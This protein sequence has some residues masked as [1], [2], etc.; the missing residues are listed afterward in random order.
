MSNR[1]SIPPVDGV[2]SYLTLLNTGHQ[3]GLTTV[4]ANGVW[5]ADVGHTM[6]L[7]PTAEGMTSLATVDGGANAWSAN[8]GHTM[9]FRSTAAG[10][11]SF[12]AYDVLRVTAEEFRII[13][14][15]PSGDAR[16]AGD[17]ACV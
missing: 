6:I 5:P 1:H 2:A 16:D 13:R 15:D 14:G 17:E 3:G 4:H 7:G 8:A 10:K 11:T 9:I 12:A